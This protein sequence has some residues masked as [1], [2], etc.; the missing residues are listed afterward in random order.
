MDTLKTIIKLVKKDCF[1]ASI[2]AYYS[3]TMAT[4]DAKYLRFSWRGQFYQFICSYMLTQWH[5]MRPE[6]LPNVLNLPLKGYI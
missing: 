5:L 1:I 6:N 2:D 4:S 3:V